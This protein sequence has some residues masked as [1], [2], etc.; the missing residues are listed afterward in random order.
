[1]TQQQEQAARCCS[2]SCISFHQSDSR[3]HSRHTE[4]CVIALGLGVT[5]VQTA[6]TSVLWSP[7]ALLIFTLGALVLF[8][9]QVQS[10]LLS[11]SL[12]LSYASLGKLVEQTVDYY[13]R[14]CTRM[15]S[16]A[17]RGLP[18]G[19]GVWKSLRLV[20]VGSNAV[21][22]QGTVNLVP[23]LWWSHVSKVNFWNSSDSG[24]FSVTN[25]QKC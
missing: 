25:L 5:V 16:H 4:V 24:A 15:Y 7:L 22:S 3:R 17:Q 13:C 19:S 18:L 1:M 20:P 2:I 10:L 23:N 21:S 11:R 6:R 14:A 9:H 12:L 8:A